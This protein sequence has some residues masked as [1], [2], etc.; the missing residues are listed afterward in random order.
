M[1]RDDL[2]VVLV[3]TGPHCTGG[4]WSFVAASFPLPVVP[5][6]GAPVPAPSLSPCPIP[7]STP[8]RSQWS[9]CQAPGGKIIWIFL[10]P[11]PVWYSGI[12]FRSC[13]LEGCSC[14]FQSLSSLDEFSLTQKFCLSKIL[15]ALG[16]NSLEQKS[17]TLYLA[18]FPL[19]ISAATIIILFK[20]VDASN[21]LRN[22]SI[23]FK[24]IL[25]TKRHISW[26]Y[27]H[28]PS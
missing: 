23:I 28:V 8:S 10:F 24:E 6:C 11:F 7:L 22:M 19:C 4:K 12:I 14:D 25:R 18:L 27:F 9:S 13:M 1:L 26:H 21:S 15:S 5:L 3:S 20:T 17:K 2:R 16:S